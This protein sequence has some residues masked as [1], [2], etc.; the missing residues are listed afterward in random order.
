MGEQKPY[1]KP[2]RRCC[3]L[4]TRSILR[5]SFGKSRRHS[6]YPKRHGSTRRRRQRAPENYTKLSQRVSQSH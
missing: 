4:L 5:G 2:G 1:S 3:T 6:P